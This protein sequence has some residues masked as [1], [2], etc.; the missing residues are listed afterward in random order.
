MGFTKTAFVVWAPLAIALG[1]W[2]YL[3]V[4]IG[5]MSVIPGMLVPD[6]SSMIMAPVF[7][8]PQF[9][10]LLLMWIV[11]MAAMMLST[12]L[13]LILAYARMKAGDTSHEKSWVYVLLLSLGYI[14]TW[15][16]FSIAATMLHGAF[17]VFSVLSPMQMAITSGPVAGALLILAGV[18]QF[19]PLKQACLSQCRSPM[20]FLMTQWR[21]S[22]WGTFTMG[23]SHGLYCVG[24]CWALMVLLFVSGVMNVVFILALTAYILIEKVFLF[25]RL[26][27][28]GV[29]IALMGTGLWFLTPGLVS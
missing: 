2:I 6:M 20:S 21:D 25:S 13:P 12:A 14:A 11:M 15:A 7:G 19:T 5:D 24:C 26:V 10:G 28:N 18:Y 1:S 3:S 17:S 29:G 4:M 23:W 16:A 9:F 27:T 8:V 22:R